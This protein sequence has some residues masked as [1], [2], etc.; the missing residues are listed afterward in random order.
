MVKP[1]SQKPVNAAQI[2]YLLIYLVKLFFC[3]ACLLTST[4]CQLTFVEGTRK[5]EIEI[6]GL[7]ITFFP[8]T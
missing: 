6:M 2:L 4:S 3:A 8:N 7:D 5:K 1:I